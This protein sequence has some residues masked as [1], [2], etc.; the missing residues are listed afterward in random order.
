MYGGEWHDGTTQCWA[1]IVPCFPSL[2]WNGHV[3]VLMIARTSSC[4]GDF[5]APVNFIFTSSC[6]FEKRHRGL[7]ACFVF[8]HLI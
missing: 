1:E 7:C 5:L 8:E 6:D 3:E 2:F 4:C